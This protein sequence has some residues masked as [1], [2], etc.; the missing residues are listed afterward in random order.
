MLLKT[1]N[2]IKGPSLIK[3]TNNC[4]VLQLQT[5]LSQG[6]HRKNETLTRQ[7]LC[8]TEHSNIEFIA[9]PGPSCSKLTTSLVNVSLKFQTLI[10]EICQYFCRKNMRSFCSA[11]ASLIFFNKKYHC[12]V[13]L[14]WLEHLWDHRSLFETGVV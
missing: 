6:I 9:S 4:E 14:Q 1:N 12:T 5:Q 13:E 11:K 2:K 8:S 10:S 7:P 3:P